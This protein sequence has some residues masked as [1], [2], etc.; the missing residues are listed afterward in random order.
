MVKKM[1]V[2]ITDEV[3][4]AL[5][6]LVRETSLARSRLIDIL[7]R[8]HPRV[9]QHMSQQLEVPMICSRCGSSLTGKDVRISTPTYGVLCLNCWS[10]RAGEIID[11]HPVSDN[12]S[13][14]EP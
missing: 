9:R 13:H 6:N 12:D 11:R 10:F 8:E 7:L 1:G 14:L 2:C 3:S 5:D 4:F